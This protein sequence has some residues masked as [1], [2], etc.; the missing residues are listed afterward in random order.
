[1]WIVS[2]SDKALQNAPRQHQCRPITTRISIL[3]RDMEDL[4]SMEVRIGND[5]SSQDRGRHLVL[6]SGARDSVIHLRTWQPAGTAPAVERLLRSFTCRCHEMNLEPKGEHTV[7][8]PR[9]R[10]DQIEPE[11][12]DA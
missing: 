6:D 4:R 9:P 10:P 2:S 11:D 5:F 12:A 8:T 3:S 1:M 7:R